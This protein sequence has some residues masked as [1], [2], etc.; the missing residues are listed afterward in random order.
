MSPF[1]LL[2]PAAA[3][4]AAGSWVSY[5]PA[6]KAWRWFPGLMIALYVANGWLWAL[7]ARWSA[8]DRQL[9][10]VSVAWDVA[11]LAAYNLL[12]L[13]VCGVRLSPTAL[14]GVALVVLGACLVKWG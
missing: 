6:V 9:Y 1:L 14:A 2:I 7:A 5:S 12:P 10:S 8:S 13:V 11:T 4:L 3:V